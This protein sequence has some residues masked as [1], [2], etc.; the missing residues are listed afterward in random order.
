MCIVTKNQ[1]GHFAKM[2]KYNE[3]VTK[4][5]DKAARNVVKYMQWVTVCVPVLL[6]EEKNYERW[7]IIAREINKLRRTLFG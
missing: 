7:F 2:N 5:I 4:T 1:K 3:S 6:Y